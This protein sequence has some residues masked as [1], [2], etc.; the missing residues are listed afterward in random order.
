MNSIKALSGSIFFH[1]ACK[2]GHHRKARTLAICSLARG[3]RKQAYLRFTISKRSSSE[4]NSRVSHAPPNRDGE[5]KPQLSRGFVV[6][7]KQQ[8]GEAKRRG[9]WRPFFFD[10]KEGVYPLPAALL[11]SPHRV[12]G[13]VES[14][15]TSIPDHELGIRETPIPSAMQP[16]M[17]RSQIGDT[18]S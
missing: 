18:Q 4:P 17:Q 9:V 7:S 2:C 13:W 10:F 5:L 12:K 8:E 14:R 3:F 11:S 1:P 16:E 15:L 6:A